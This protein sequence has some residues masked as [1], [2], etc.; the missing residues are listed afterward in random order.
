MKRISSTKEKNDV[1]TYQYRFSAHRFISY[2]TEQ[3]QA[4]GV[5]KEGKILIKQKLLF[6]QNIS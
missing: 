3:R 1:F 6:K 4:W 5:T 2:E